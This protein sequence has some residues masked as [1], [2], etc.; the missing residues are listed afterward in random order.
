[1]GFIRIGNNV[2]QLENTFLL[3]LRCAFCPPN[4]TDSEQENR[5]STFSSGIG[6]FISIHGRY[7]YVR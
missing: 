1:M 6:K 4:I 3:E 7:L 5:F 2:T